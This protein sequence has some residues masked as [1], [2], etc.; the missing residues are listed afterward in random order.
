MRLRKLTILLLAVALIGAV[1]AVPALAEETGGNGDALVSGRGW[2]W[3]K[4]AGEV[5]FDMGGRVQLLI[6]GDVTIS[7]FAGDMKVKIISED[8]FRENGIA[9]ADEE[10]VGSD[11]TLEDFRGYVAVE[12]THFLLE[13]Q[14]KARLRAHGGG[15]AY[16][17]GRGW[18]KTDS[19][20]TVRWTSTGT[21]VELAG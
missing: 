19:G 3:A 13:A 14:G 15:V 8:T 21:E 4:G 16:L 11:L 17:A 6:D 10:Y 12:G 20:P 7:D 2:L 9:V 1:L 5:R 18:Y